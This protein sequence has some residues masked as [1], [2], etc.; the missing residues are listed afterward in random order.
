MEK[1]M[2]GIHNLKS[3][4]NKGP[5]RV[6][7]GIGSGHGKTATRGMNGALQRGSIRPGF[8]GG[9]TPIQRRLRKLK[10]VSQ[11]AMNIGIFKKKYSI[12]NVE[13]LNVLEAGTVV[14]PELLAN[15]RIISDLADGLRVL[16]NGE[17][18]KALTVK[19]NHFSSSAAEKIKAA[20]GSVEVI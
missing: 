2:I 4:P 18:E 5:K 14:T 15:M 11:S 16:G 1:S 8:E 12:I 10:G 17:L 13:Q 19:A 9:Q 20:G 7:R 3:S 6:G